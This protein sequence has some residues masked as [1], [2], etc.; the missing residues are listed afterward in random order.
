M[1]FVINFFLFW[2]KK[3]INTH[4]IRRPLGRKNNVRKISLCVS[5]YVYKS[6]EIEFPDYKK[7]EMETEMSVRIK[8]K[9][10][11]VFLWQLDFI[12]SLCS[13]FIFVRSISFMLA[14]PY[15]LLWK[16]NI[17]PITRPWK[18]HGEWQQQVASLSAFIFLGC[19]I[20]RAFFF[21]F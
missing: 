18:K 16:I 2:A 9:L 10:W 12:F 20:L 14:A 5:V 7:L 6:I 19:Y 13:L 21:S 17:P 8:K 3:I 4:Y 11:F 1:H 15:V